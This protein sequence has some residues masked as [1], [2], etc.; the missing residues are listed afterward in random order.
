MADQLDDRTYDLLFGI[1]RSVRYHNH[2]RRF[3]ELW[4]TF[5]VTAAL[6]GGSAGVVALLPQLGVSWLAPTMS[7]LVAVV[8]A[9]DLAVGTGR[10]ADLHGDL[11]RQFIGLEQQFAHDRDLDDVEFEKLT[12]ARLRI[13][14]SEPPVLRLLDAMCHFELLRSLGDERMHPRVPLRRRALAHW[15]SQTDFALR[16][17]RST[18]KEGQP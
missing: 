14:A 8:A 4:N 13:E 2:R 12:K 9:L 6:V 11:A 16:L 5:T 17:G 1:R 18:Q 15:I 10:R 7:A 3:Y